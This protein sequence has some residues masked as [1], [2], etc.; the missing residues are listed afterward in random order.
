MILQSRHIRLNFRFLRPTAR[1]A[2]SEHSN[3]LGVPS[4]PKLLKYVKIV[5][6][7]GIAIVG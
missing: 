1:S 2:K 3:L 7:L 6:A 4:G 5:P